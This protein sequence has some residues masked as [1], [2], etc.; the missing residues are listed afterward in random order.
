MKQL[1]PILLAAFLAACGGSDSNDSPAELS[2]QIDQIERQAE[3]LG[4]DIDN[5]LQ[6]L[7]QESRAVAGPSSIVVSQLSADYQAQLASHAA[8]LKECDALHQRIQQQI[9]DT[10]ELNFS[11][12]A[13][14]RALNA[15]QV[16]ACRQ[17][18]ELQPGLDNI[19]QLLDAMSGTL[20]ALEQKVADAK[21]LLASLSSDAENIQ[22]IAGP[23]G[24]KGIQGLQGPKGSQGAQG[25]QGDE[26]D[27]G[28]HFTR[29][30]VNALKG[31]SHPD[32]E[33][34]VE[35]DRKATEIEKDLEAMIALL[36]SMHGKVAAP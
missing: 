22:L 23:M 27:E 25:A 31:F 36:V 9:A 29:S 1:T 18:P 24:P 13:E 10:P 32:G 7:E 5:S 33:A 3:A 21:A 4:Q 17:L 16:E 30:D 20:L 26:G 12:L 11:L 35:N 2:R 19:A 28:A 6:N 34:I 14:L 15:E 8:L